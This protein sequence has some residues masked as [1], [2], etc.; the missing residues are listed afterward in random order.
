MMGRADACVR[1]CITPVAPV[2]VSGGCWALLWH[3]QASMACNAQVPAAPTQTAALLAAE[4][5][6]TCQMMLTVSTCDPVKGPQ[7]F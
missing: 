3:C 2:W 4:R 6:S 5:P 1:C 7:C